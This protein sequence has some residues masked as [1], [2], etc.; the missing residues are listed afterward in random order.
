M[1]TPAD[2]YP[3]HQTAEPIAHPGSGDRNH[4]DRYF[5]NGHTSD[6]SLF[7][8]AAMGFYPNRQVIDGAF[9][10]VREGV[11]R[12]VFASGR[13][14]PD[15]RQTRIGPVRIEVVE[16]LRTLRLVVDDDESGLGA[17]LTF[18]ARSA[19]WEEPRFTR[20]GHG[21]RL[22]MDY[23]RLTQWGRWSGT[24]QVDGERIA[25]QPDDVVGVRDRSWGIR[26]VGER[27]PGVPGP[28]PQFYWLWAPLHFDDHCL[29]F[30]FNDSAEGIP[31][32]ASGVVLPD[33][34]PGAATWGAGVPGA[35]V[36]AVDHETTWRTGTRRAERCRLT[37]EPWRAD[38]I[39]VELEPLVDF[40]MR[41]VG[42]L[43]PEF[44]HGAWLGEEVVGRET[45]VLADIDPLDPANLHVQSVVRAT[46][47]ERVGV[48]VL[49]QLVIGPHEPSGLVGLL[50]G[51]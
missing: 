23:T 35:A 42:Y 13:I 24:V 36:R 49:E 2:D 22:V 40:Q 7:F 20:H 10:V 8:S 47:G 17:E 26:T 21:T 14:P 38:P 29:H 51:A 44:R 12:S 32:Y 39:E 9:S 33:L 27:D 31:W 16:P 46:A 34:E 19:A 30:A 1:L 43:H 6:G 48:G 50:D 37:L 15:R 41:G 3:L 5:F 18:E 11:Q 25:V 45:L 28:M 4:Y